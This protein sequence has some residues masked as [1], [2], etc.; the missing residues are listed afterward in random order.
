MSK[1][2]KKT[3][4]KVTVKLDTSQKVAA[5]VALT[6]AA[7]AA[8][9]VYFLHGSPQAKQNRKK[10]KSWMLKAKAEVLEQLEKADEMTQSQFDDIIMQVSK[11]YS[12]V[13]DA[14]GT[15]IADFKREMKAYWPKIA[16]EGKVITATVATMASA[17]KKKAS[18]GT[19]KVT[20]KAKKV[21]KKKSTKKATKKTTKKTAKKSVK[22][23]TKKSTKKK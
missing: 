6:A 3:T 4:K 16:K 17:A 9:G 1:K 8:A 18:A 20:V 21:A 15:D 12:K 14:T 7:V 10:V 23:T 11:A 19:K 13:Q 5:G 22:K 2:S